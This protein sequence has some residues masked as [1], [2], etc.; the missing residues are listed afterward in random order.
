MLYEI[1]TILRYIFALHS[2]TTVRENF[3]ILFFNLKILSRKDYDKTKSIV[4]IDFVKKMYF[5]EF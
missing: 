4:F 2:V 5:L 3:L 1:S